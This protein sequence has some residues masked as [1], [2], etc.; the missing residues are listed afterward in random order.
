MGFIDETYLL[1]SEAAVD[2]YESIADLPVVDPHNH[3]DLA[4]VVDDD[5][6]DDVWEVEG[7]TDHYVWQ[8]M[9][10]RGVPE[11][12]VTGDASN[13]EKWDALA[14]VFPDFAGNPTYD[15]VH[16]DL[17]RRFGIEKPLSADTADEIW[18]ETKRQLSEPEMRPQA[19]LREM[20]VEVLCSS[21]D[22][23]SR[24]EYHERAE[25]EVEG[26]DVRPTWRPD[27]ALK[28]EKP[29]WDEFV[30][31]LDAATETDVDDFEGFRDALAETHDYFADHG[32]VACDIG[33]GTDPVSAPV[34]DE[35]AAAVYDRARRGANLDEGAV[36]DFKA[37]L[38]EFVGELNAE[39]GW[40][41]QLHVGAVRDYRASLYERVGANAGG[42]VSTSD[43]DV[44]GGLD[45]F[46]DR[47]DGEMEVVLYTLDPTH[48]PDVTVLARA[49]PN[50]SVGPAWWFN[51]SPMG[52]A[53]QLERVA[54]VDLLANHAGMVSDSRKLVSYGSRFEMFRRTLANLVGRMV[55][56]GRV[57]YDNAERLVEHVAYDRPKE[58]Y[59]L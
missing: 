31:E 53:N 11:E 52:M 30:V 27:R 43:V 39:K 59:G 56:R 19:L 58:L 42:D 14:A 3:V 29:A 51:D 5:P 8:H 20:N 36:R 26:V 12:K 34:S 50:V 9:R 25:T 44:V 1:D 55:D 23:T 16:L 47:F 24:L 37:Y 49:Y 45:H 22:P 33:T 46:L 32:C 48:Y 54:S 38:L 57:P 7:A 28:V 13:R 4:E 21:D 35:R 18:E 2:L 15:W 17:E 10:E 40:V 6:W 41:T